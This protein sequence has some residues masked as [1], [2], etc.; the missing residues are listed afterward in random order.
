[1]GYQRNE[2]NWCAMN[3]IIGDNQCTILF[4]VDYLKS[5]HVGPADISSVLSGIDAEYGRIEKWPS[6]GGKFINTSG[7]PL[8]TPRLARYYSRWFTTLE[9]C[10]TILHNTW[11]RNQPHLLRITSF[12]MQDATKFSQANTDIFHHFVAQLLY[13]LNSARP[14]I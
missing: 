9:R 7:W 10:L 5:S 14:D 1:M 13:I 3:R 6:R 12:T 2:Y 4:H 8:I 11:R